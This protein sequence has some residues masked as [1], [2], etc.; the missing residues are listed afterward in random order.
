MPHRRTKT[1]NSWHFWWS[2]HQS[3][4]QKMC[5]AMSGRSRGAGAGAAL[6][7]APCVLAAGGPIELST[8]LRECHSI[9]RGPQIGL[10]SKSHPCKSWSLLTSVLC[11]FYV[12]FLYFNT[13]LA[14]CLNRFLIV[15]A[16]IS[17]FS[18]KEA[19]SIFRVLWNFAKS[20][21]Q[22]YCWL[23]AGRAAPLCN[24]ETK[25]SDSFG[26]FSWHN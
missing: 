20:R 6:C 8:G 2:L 9:H 5:A 1:L 17:T 22:L 12:N 16:L 4:H 3:H 23:L 7:F 25:N 10:V 24:G 14:Y 13:Q 11:Q 26:S 19:F 21:W 15:K 18:K